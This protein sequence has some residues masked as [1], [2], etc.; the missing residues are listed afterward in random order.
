MRSRP[1][2]HGGDAVVAPPTPDPVQAQITA[3]LQSLH[4]NCLTGLVAGLEA[5][6]SGDLT[7]RVDPVTTPVDGVSADPAVQA[8]VEL[9]N[10]MLTKAQAALEG[11]NAVREEL[12]AALGDRS[13]LAE[14]EER[15][16]SLDGHCLTQL[17][18][19]LA[20]VAGGDLTVAARAVTSPLVPERG[21]ALGRLGDIFNSMLT[22]A[23]GGLESYNAMRG[24]IGSLIRDIGTGSGRVAASAEQMSASSQQTSAAIQEIAH[25][26]GHVAEGAEK[27][28]NMV[29]E[30]SEIT[31]E[32]VAVAASAKQV[33]REGISL[34]VEIAKIADQ[35]NL[36]ALNAAI[37]AARAGEQG[38]GFA[39]VAEE[40]R[41]LAESASRTVDQTRDAFDGL[42]NEIEKVSG[43]IDRIDHATRG[44]ADV[45]AE[46]SAASEQV[47]AS[48][49]ESSASTQQVSAS[50]GTLL[51]L[52][53]ELDRLVTT[54]TV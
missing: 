46:S 8:Q 9:F 14:L 10:S 50:S 29:K 32:A 13:C 41:K 45:A 11:Y 52:A 33:A 18:E 15:L 5:M 48:A 53:S 40:V 38:R 47:S 28:V 21:R 51:E 4:D 43:Y 22:Q 7:V 1:F 27:Q 37:E 25:A 54:F 6:R 23:Q 24:Q 26:A 39:V 35:T 17:G 42:A 3:G 49:Q 16:T 30:T 2:F 20:A 31:Q 12:R 34:T 44:V 36:L 19:G